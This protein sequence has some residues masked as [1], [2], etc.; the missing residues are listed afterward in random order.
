MRPPSV[1]VFIT[2]CNEKTYLK[3][4][5]ED[6][7]R[8]DFGDFEILLLEA[9]ENHKSLA[10]DALKKRAPLLHY[11]HKKG[12]SRA[13]AL[14]QLVKKSTGEVLIRLD[15]RTH[16][17]N[18]YISKI[19]ELSE[20]TGATNVGGVMWPV[21]ET[22]DQRVVAELMKSSWVFGGAKF[23]KAGFQGE[24]ETVYLG[25][26]RK[27][28]IP[29]EDWY[30][31][32][33]SKISEDSDLN[34]RL[35]NIGKKVFI[36]SSIVAY[37]YPRENLAKFFKLCFNYGLGRS[38][39]I[40]KHKS[41]LAPRQLVFVTGA[42]LCA[43]LLGASLSSPLCRVLF[44]CLSSAYLGIAFALALTQKAKLNHKAKFFLGV[45]GAHFC[46]LTGLLCGPIQYHKDL[47]PRGPTSTP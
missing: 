36:D 13:L 39:F 4:I 28:D 46:W 9:G 30:D 43:F 47:R 17:E 10:L 2:T 12:A 14:N 25:A 11:F 27:K 42:I 24:A 19:V 32:D 35:R 5:L 34:F 45:V 38:I 26:F 20:T 8:Q 23:R 1:S 29:F 33:C 18:N 41:A 40:L 31:S 21:G 7:D 37:H 15:A 22:K 3:R 6:L 44:I 16:I